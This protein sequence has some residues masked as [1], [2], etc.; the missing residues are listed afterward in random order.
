MLILR[1][2]PEYAIVKQLITKFAKL[3]SKWLL[4]NSQSK[5]QRINKVIL[6]QG[7]FTKGLQE[8]CKT[9]IMSSTYKG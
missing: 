5:K 3:F 2:S 6:I 7:K 8:I 1:Q 9:Q 4:K